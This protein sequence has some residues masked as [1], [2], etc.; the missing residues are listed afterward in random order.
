MAQSITI[1]IND[2]IKAQKLLDYFCLRF[3]YDEGGAETKKDF[4]K[5]LTIEWWR[6]EAIQ[7][8]RKEQDAGFMDEFSDS[9]IIIV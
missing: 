3:G 5:R 2:D 9:N 7:G 8:K 6:N 1:T 4:V